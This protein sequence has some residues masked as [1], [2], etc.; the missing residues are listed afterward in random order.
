M[1]KLIHVATITTP[2]GVKGDFKLRCFLESSKA[3]GKFPALYN[4]SGD[5]VELNF[6][7]LKAT[8]PI[9]HMQGIDDRNDVEPIRGMKLFAQE[10]DFPN[11]QTGEFYAHQLVGLTVNDVEGNATGKTIA[12]HNFGAGDILEVEFSDGA[13]E[14]LPFDEHTFPEVDLEKGVM[15]YTP[16]EWME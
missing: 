12:H 5:A 1:S 13:T 7:S 11:A 15:T 14:M 3:V 9:A 10:N 16:P 4:E 2:H 6:V 8:Q